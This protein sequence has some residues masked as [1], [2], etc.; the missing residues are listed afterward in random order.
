MERLQ[1]LIPAAALFILAG[2]YTIQAEKY[3]V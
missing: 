3:T 2:K 1:E